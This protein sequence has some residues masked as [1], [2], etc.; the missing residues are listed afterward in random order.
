MVWLTQCVCTAYIGSLTHTLSLS[1]YYV[2]FLY[3]KGF[4]L[5]QHIYVHAC[6]YYDCMCDC[7]AFGFFD[8]FLIHKIIMKKLVVGSL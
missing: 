4:S 1:L 6:K 5:L 3:G 8:F 7:V 2:L